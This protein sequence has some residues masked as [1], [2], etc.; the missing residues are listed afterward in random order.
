MCRRY[1]VPKTRS[2]RESLNPI[3]S[4]IGEYRHDRPCTSKEVVTSYPS[5]S[6]TKYVVVNVK[7]R[8]FTIQEVECWV[9][10]LGH[11]TEVD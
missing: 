3:T 4:E 1:P 2:I 11:C 9:T 5:V 8:T 6:T 7:S 10:G